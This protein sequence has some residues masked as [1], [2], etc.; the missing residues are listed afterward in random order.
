VARAPRSTRRQIV[1]LLLATT[2]AALAGATPQ[3]ARVVD[4]AATLRLA[5]DAAYTLDPEAGRVHVT[6]Q[7]TATS[8]KP[9]TSSFIY[10]YREIFF[11]IQRE[12]TTIRASD[13]SGAISVSTKKHPDYIAATVRLRSNLYYHDTTHFTIRFDLAGGD[14]RSDSPTR[15]GAAFATFGVWAWG[16][17]GRSTVNG[18]TP[19]GFASESFGDTLTLHTGTNGQDLSA[20]PAKPGTFF[21]IVD[22]ENR[23]AY[24]STRLSFGSGAEVVILAWPEDHAWSRNVQDVLGDGIP[25]LRSLIGLS[26]PVAHDLNVFERYTPALEGYAGVFFTDDQHIDVS[27]DLDPIVV[28][29]EASHAWFNQALF[30]ER[31]IY[32]GLAEEYAW[33]VLGNL[34]NDANRD[35]ERPDPKDPGLITLA[36]WS[37]PQ[38]IRDQ[39]TDDRERYGYGA[40]FWVLH[41]IA[42]SAGEDGMRAAFA[43]ARFDKTA[44]VGAGAPERV[45]IEDDWR[46]FLDLVEPIDRPDAPEVEAAIRTYVLTP[47]EATRLDAR[48]AA[49][50]KYRALVA[51]GDG[52]LPPWVVRAP[53]GT[54]AFSTATDAMGHATA[55][56][57]LRKQVDEAAAALD[58]EPDD[59]LQRAYEDATESF[60]DATT[61]ANDELKALAAIALAR[62]NVDATPD[63]VAQVG[64]MGETPRTPYNAARAAFEAGDLQAAARQAAAATAIITGAP[65]V[66]QTRL[67][68]AGGG[69][70]VA[71]LMLLLAVLLLRRRSGR[72]RAL[73]AAT[74]TLAADPGTAAPEM[75]GGPEAPTA[76]HNEGDKPL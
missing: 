60:D 39:E 26:W 15:V 3:A 22:S 71:L 29:H 70:V 68:I 24:A 40:A 64:L 43:A 57:A 63:F 38:V 28:V 66:G 69:L 4:A 6:I 53:M 61:I 41:T 31:W 73:V 1:G 65:A 50:K 14:P 42:A 52:W 36:A 16:D 45:A 25:E 11:A 67:L 32:E 47:I 34:G 23:N 20:S 76:P 74:T 13:S 17:P 59:A 75:P 21:A 56:L 10:F 27:E 55:V 8:L 72:R 51:A 58:L 19:R 62:T 33:R 2:L 46:R 12:A 44:Y 49:R 48:D 30:K 9:N 18:H 54:W 37:F 5:A 35:P 7:A